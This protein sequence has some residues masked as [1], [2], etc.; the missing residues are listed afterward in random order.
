MVW[1]RNTFGHVG[2]KIARLQE[3]LQ[4]LEGRKSSINVMEE[5]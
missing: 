4:G 1:N 3:K 2:R 5:I